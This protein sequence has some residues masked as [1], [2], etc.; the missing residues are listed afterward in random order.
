MIN[1]R[2]AFAGSRVGDF[3]RRNSAILVSYLI[4]LA[5]VVVGTASH[6]TLPPTTTFGISRCWPFVGI[7]GLGQTL[8]ILTGGIDLSV[9]W[10]LTGS[11]VLTAIVAGGNAAR[12]PLAILLVLALAV[13]VGLINGIGIAYA[14]VPPIIMTLGMNGCLQGLLLVYTNGGF[15]SAPPPQLIAF[16]T[17]STLG[18]I[19]NDILV[20]VLVDRPSERPSSPS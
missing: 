14:G 6:P 10:V 2:S 5:L 7:A 16:V 9:P 18:G 11:A 3:A 4:V 8:C 15:S 13:G 17:G 1:V 20:W 12:L 19:S